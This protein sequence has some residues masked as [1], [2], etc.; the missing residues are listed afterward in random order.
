MW[1]LT[2]RGKT[3]RHGTLKPDYKLDKR[4]IQINMHMRLSVLNYPEL[5]KIC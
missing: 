2:T 1:T 5:T 4:I 3:E